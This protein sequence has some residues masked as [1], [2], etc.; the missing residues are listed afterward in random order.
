M[1]PNPNH[2]AGPVPL[3]P[4][5]QA[6]SAL[7]QTLT[8]RLTNALTESISTAVADALR[9]LLRRRLSALRM[10][11]EEHDPSSRRFQC[12]RGD[13]SRLLAWKLARGDPSNN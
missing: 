3:P 4:W 9:R 10:P 13:L 5:L 11:P 8:V 12:Q 2:P 1:Q 6:D 7:L